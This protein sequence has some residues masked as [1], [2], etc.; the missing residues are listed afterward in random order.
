MANFTPEE[1]EEILQQFFDVTGKRQYIGARYVPIFGRKNEDSIEWNNSA[2]Y[3]PLSIVLYQGNS[4]TSRTYVPADVPITDTHFWVN[5]GN[6]NAQVEQYR[7]DTAAVLENMTRLETSLTTDME[8]LDLRL[9]GDIESL[10][11][12]INETEG[13]IELHSQGVKNL[14]ELGADPTG[15]L[16]SSDILQSAID[17]YKS[18]I[19]PAG[20]FKIS[21]IVNV[22]T[23]CAL[24]GFGNNSIINIIGDGS[25]RFVGESK[26]VYINGIQFE[27]SKVTNAAIDIS[28]NTTVLAQPRINISNCIFILDTSIESS[29]AAINLYGAREAT[30]TSCIFSGSTIT[31]QNVIGIRASADE[32]HLT[33]NV[34]IVNCSFAYLGYAFDMHTIKE[35]RIYLAGFR[36]VSSTIIG[37][38]Y[39]IKCNN[40]D[41]LTVIGCMIDYCTYPTYFESIINL[42]MSE[43]YLQTSDGDSCIYIENTSSTGADDNI[44]INGCSFHSSSGS[45]TPSENTVDGI[46]LVGGTSPG[47]I[48][49][50]I[51]SNNT[52]FRLRNAI[53][54]SNTQFLQAQGNV[55]YYSQSFIDLNENCQYPTLRGNYAQSDVTTVVRN[56][57]ATLV[58][59]GQQYGARQSGIVQ[60]G[61]QAFTVEANNSQTYTINFPIPFYAVPA[62]YAYFNALGDSWR[63]VL[64]TVTNVTINNM[65]VKIVNGDSASHSNT[66]TWNA[67]A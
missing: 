33:M 63:D 53:N 67:I 30:I 18:V 4:Y 21:N 62:A 19:I 59:E 25:I 61:Y 34:G 6:Y 46:K 13:T 20:K 55:I 26:Y 22:T 38:T 42:T 39:G 45:T 54:A 37:C 50:V 66:F 57:V 5:T 49:H 32:N 1:L 10:N 47:I 16:D 8:N 36:V 12:R 14:I 56:P 43:C 11:D 9:T 2:P 23:D 29:A 48:R 3:E 44:Y 17:T 27:I 35:S 65:T 52:M 40:F 24:S 64:I 7:R 58:N 51:I 15:E 28:R 41:T 60:H 31:K